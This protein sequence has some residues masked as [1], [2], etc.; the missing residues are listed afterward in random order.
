MQVAPLPAAME[1]YLGALQTERQLSP[2]TLAAYRR[3]LAKLCAFAASEP[4]SPAAE[5]LESHQLRRF[6]ARLHAQGLAPRSIARTL[7]GWR[8][9]FAW[10]ALYEQCPSNPLSGVRA[11]KAGRRLPKALSAD[12]AVRL[13]TEPVSDDALGIRDHAIFELF[14]SSGL[15]LSELVGL[16]A[17]FH[18]EG[19]YR[20]AGWI[21]LAEGEVTVT[22]KGGRRRSVPVGKPARQALAAWLG[23]RATLLKADARPLFVSRDGA[24]LSP[25]SIQVRLKAHARRLGIPANVHPHVLRHSFASHVLQSSGDLRAVQEMLGHASIAATQIYTSLDFQRL[26]AVYDAAHPRAHKNPK[27][28]RGE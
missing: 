17:A 9:F 16:D 2:H 4:R 1:R 25:R 21:D 11:P 24:R 7:S 28:S 12:L 19:R 13:V 5:A 18:A 20:S 26:A 27:K 22:G 14:Y 6:A 3:D 10:L 15:R 8:T 23:V